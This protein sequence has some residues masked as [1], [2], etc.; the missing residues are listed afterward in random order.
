MEIN[1]YT[2]IRGVVAN[3]DIPEGRMGFITANAFTDGYN[4]GSRTDLPGVSLPTSDAEA[5]LSKFVITWRVPDQSLPM[6]LPEPSVPW[7]L[8]R[9]FGGAANLPLTGT[10]VHLTWP[11]Q[12]HGVT[13]PSG[14]LCLAFAGGS[15]TFPSGHYV[16]SADI[17]IVGNPV[18]VEGTDGGADQGKPE[19]SV[20]QVVGYVERYDSSTG[21]LE[22][23][24]LNP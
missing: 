17:R 12:K 20:T 15:F 22:I 2:D 24:T 11:G 13:I 9:G 16:D 14:Q 3:E 4:F 18:S 1:K 19:Y 7:S 21:D 6:Y 23:R 5:A 10:T 8:R